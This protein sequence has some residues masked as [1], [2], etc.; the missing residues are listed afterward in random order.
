MG[1]SRIHI[2]EV[3]LTHKQ[4]GYKL[5]KNENIRTS[6][7]KPTHAHMQI[8]THALHGLK[9]EKINKYTHNHTHLNTHKQRSALSRRKFPRM[10]THVGLMVSDRKHQMSSEDVAALVLL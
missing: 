5:P 7:A 6:Y 3:T 1:I 8:N 10:I 2:H 4:S 9:Q